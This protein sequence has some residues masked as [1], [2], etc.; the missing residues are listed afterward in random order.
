[1]S[2]IVYE[3]KY[4]NEPKKL[5]YMGLYKPGTIKILQRLFK[6]SQ[7]MESELDKDLFDFSREELRMLCY[8]YAPKTEH[9]SKANVSWLSKYIDWAIE[10][11]YHRGLNPLDTVDSSWKEQFVVKNLK[12]YWT[13]KEIAEIID[14]V[15]RANYQDSVI[16]SLLSEGARGVGYSEIL[17]L[18]IKDINEEQ[19]ELKLTDEDDSTRV[20]KVSDN[21]IKHCLKAIDETKYEKMNGN[22]N[23]DI[24]ATAAN[25]IENDYV[26]R[27]ANTRTVHT[28]EADTHI[29]NRR[30]SKIADEI[31]EPNFTPT[32]VVYSGMLAKAKDLLVQNGVLG[33]EEYTAIAK[34]F[35]RD[36]EQ[37]LYRLKQDFLNVETIE[38]IYGKVLD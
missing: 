20:I 14:P 5:E 17:K 4:Y 8:L 26:V 25:L 9:S 19:N 6:V 33:E 12:K 18:M 38:K 13:D 7:T 24:K 10:C 37:S 36:T 3:D 23:P 2:N 1:M 31:G 32:A 15:K 29:V 11:G 35:G 16:I 34:Q 30:I 28:E 21:C 22:A 27:S